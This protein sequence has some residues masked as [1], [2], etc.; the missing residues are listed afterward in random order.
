[1]ADIFVSYASQ[2]RSLV[3]PLVE[4]L[5]AEGYSVWWDRR[6]EAGAEFSKN[7]EFELDN[8]KVVIV[9]W[10]VSA[11]DSSWVKDEASAGHEQGKLIPICIDAERPPMGFRQYQALEFTGWKADTSAPAYHDL[12][13]SIR[14]RLAGE[15][16]PEVVSSVNPTNKSRPF[17][18]KPSIGSTFGARADVKLLVFK[19][20]HMTQS[21]H[22]DASQ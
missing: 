2:D 19:R 20:Q 1:L 9:A 11:N 21:G 14:S 4:R 6:I 3:A 22:L 5:E 12:C 13:Q 15:A 7:I 18:T 10:S 16:V 17:P 8:S